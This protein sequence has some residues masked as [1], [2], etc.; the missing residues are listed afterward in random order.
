MK[1]RRSLLATPVLAGVAGLAFLLYR[2][3]GLRPDFNGLLADAYVYLAAARAIAGASPG[4]LDLLQH[5]AETW[6]FPPLFPLLLASVGAG[7]QSATASYTLGAALLA[8]L[9]PVAFRWWRA[10]GIPLPP[11]A[12]LLLALALLPATLNV[13]T[14]VLSEPLFLLLTCAAAARLAGTRPT[15]A[16]W[17]FSA[18]LLACAALTRSVGVVA[19]AAFLISWTVQQAWR[20]ARWAPGVAVIPWLGWKAFQ[21]LQGYA[22]YGLSDSGVAGPWRRMQINF[23][24]FTW[25][26]TGLFD[27]AH[28]PVARW[29]LPVLVLCIVGVCLRRL[30]RG[31][32]DAWYL[33][34]YVAVMALWP[35]PDHAERF[36]YAVL[37]LLLAYAVLP[38]CQVGARLSNGF[39][40]RAVPCLLPLLVL[41]IAA[42]ASSLRLQALVAAEGTP[43]AGD[44]RA[45]GWTLQAPAKAQAQADFRRR[46]RPVLD[47]VKALPAQACVLTILPQEVLMYGERLGLDLAGVGAGATALE[48]GL[49][50]C[51]YVLMVAALPFPEVPWIEAMYPFRLLEQR[52]QPVAV[53]HWTAGA[54]DGPVLAML[55]RV[56]RP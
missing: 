54:G 20:S 48:Q 45:P 37:P 55:A 21:W 24:A 18:A 26:G 3:V 30:L 39:L 41:L 42:P 33:A 12:L 7:A 36:L 46:L 15:C 19:L 28:G 52:L 27:P 8:G 40:R 17:Y 4:D 31:R 43:L 47:A 2:W 51:P 1:T 49:A 13:A 6:P 14:N 10:L 56:A 22:D 5:I 9:L 34:G 25:H 23:A 32:F 16:D 38:A 11:A 29:L 53:E 50:R 44:L 35:Y